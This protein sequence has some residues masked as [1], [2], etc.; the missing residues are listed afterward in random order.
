MKL[1]KKKT[2]LKV[3]YF[4]HIFLFF[5][6]NFDSENEI[7]T[8]FV[9]KRKKLLFSENE[10]DENDDEE[11]EVE[12]ILDRKFSSNGITQYLIKWKNY[13]ENTWQPKKD[14]IN[15]KNLIQQFRRENPPALVVKDMQKQ[16]PLPKF[17]PQP[18]DYYKKVSLWLHYYN[19]TNFYILLTF[20]L[21]KIACL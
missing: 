3:N 1:R 21:E 7:T 12:K 2:I 15:C 13:P 20:I 18:Q 4:N 5:K 17:F 6:D 10:N 14:L 9:I 8:G 11:Y 16:L 19:M